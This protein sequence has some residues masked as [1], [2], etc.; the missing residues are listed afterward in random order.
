M[1]QDYDSAYKVFYERLFQGWN[2]PIETQVEVSRRARAIDAVIRCQKVHLQR[3]QGTAFAFFR[4]IND[5]EF[6]GPEDAL[7]RAD[8]MRIVSRAYGLLAK[9]RTESY[10]L[11]GNATLTIVCSVRPNT[12]LGIFQNGQICR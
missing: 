6:K 5:L 10:G 8:Y 4:R 11:P 12:I 1:P 7:S 2:I 9:Q 3:L